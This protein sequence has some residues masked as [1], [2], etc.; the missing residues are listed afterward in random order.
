[1]LTFPGHGLEITGVKIVVQQL[2]FP[3]HLWV[4]QGCLKMAVDLPSL[5]FQDG[6]WMFKSTSMQL[7]IPTLKAHCLINITYYL[8]NIYKQFLT[9]L[10]GGQAITERRKKNTKPHYPSNPHYFIIYDSLTSHINAQH[11]VN[12]FW[13]SCDYPIFGRLP[14]YPWAFLSHWI[15]L[16]ENQ[17]RKPY[18]FTIKIWGFPGSIFPQTNPMNYTCISIS[19]R[20]DPI[21]SACKFYSDPLYMEVS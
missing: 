21:P 9:L 11:P 14:H 5:Q 3:G 10:A 17:N 18:L 1:M 16:R 12:I 4:L 6:I 8:T 2:E 7:G 13:L 19:Y 15:G 20:L